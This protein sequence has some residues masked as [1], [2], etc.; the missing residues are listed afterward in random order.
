MDTAAK[1]GWSSIDLEHVR[2]DPALL[3]P[4]E[5]AVAAGARARW[6]PV[7]EQDGITPRLLAAVTPTWPYPAADWTVAGSGA[8]GFRL[9]CHAV[10]RAGDVVAV[11]E[12]TDPLILETLRDLRIRIVPVTCDHEGP[13]PASLAEALARRP[14]AFVH[15]PRVA[16]PTGLSVSRE[17]LAG[18]AASLDGL[19]VLE[20]DALGPLSAAS[21]MSLGTLLPDV[22]HVRSYCHAYGPELRSGVVAGPAWLVERVRRLRALDT[23]WTGRILQDTQAFLIDD[24]DTGA[25]LRQARTRYAAR[26]AALAAAL[27]AEDIVVHTT[28]GLGLWVPVA[29]E[30]RALMS[31][32]AQGVS[33]AAGS[34][35]HSRPPAGQHVYVTI[36]LL[37]DDPG[38]AITLAGLIAAAARGRP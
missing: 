14:V 11:A 7:D 23:T 6:R 36:G 13:E 35:Y 29:D 12:P 19:T 3:P 38:L 24:P 17:R 9:A 27:R 2:P 25:L 18:L 34:R 32:A 22:L 30:I 1:L 16:V 4:L 31:L 26:R 20:Y 37:P 10:A 33:V 21:P 8:D 15:Q 28:D 5:D